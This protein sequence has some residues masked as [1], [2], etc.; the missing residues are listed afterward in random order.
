M[1]SE[2]DKLSGDSV[3]AVRE[4]VQKIAINTTPA[5]GGGGTDEWLAEGAESP[6]LA[7][8]KE[9]NVRHKALEA[10]YD[11]EWR[12]LKLKY[13]KQYAPLYAQRREILIR[14]PD[15]GVPPGSEGLATPGVTN[16]WLNTFKSCAAVAELIKSQDE[17]VLKYLVDVRYSWLDDVEQS[18]FKL[19][20]E[21]AKNPYFEPEILEKT[22]ILRDE[23]DGEK[24][25]SKTEGTVIQWKEGK[26]LTK[27]IVT[28]K[29]KNKR[30]KQIR[31]ITETV[32]NDSF[33]SFFR[34]QEIPSD[35][36]FASMEDD[37]INDL[38]RLVET[39][40]DA[41]V[42]L[43]DKIIP[44]AVGWYLGEEHD[45]DEGSDDLDEDDDGDEDLSDDDE[46]DE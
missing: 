31:T 7:S 17:V 4:Q 15:R 26:D 19:I 40:F 12:L 44:R 33:F 6:E 10:E 3:E 32:V 16:F 24:V 2:N 23:P 37:D 14:V 13:M 28:R 5:A 21:F 42:A 29:Q 1:A 38:E 22:F 11:K 18:G 35:E 46:D 30:T 34:S 36:E 43:R 8:L 27:K 41:G 39:E 45:E 20:F 9:L 25:L